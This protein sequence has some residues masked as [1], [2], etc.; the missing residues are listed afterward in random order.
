ME[1]TIDVPVETA[2]RIREVAGEISDRKRS[3][4]QTQIIATVM[5]AIAEAL[6][7]FFDVGDAVVDTTTGE[8]AVV[9]ALANSGT[10]AVIHADGAGW[11]LVSCETLGR[12]DA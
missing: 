2:R 5:S 9:D 11:R 7:G 10:M 6:P 4:P 12:I 1:V 8:R 3:G